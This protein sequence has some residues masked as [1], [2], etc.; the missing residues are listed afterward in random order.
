MQ[1]IYK[2]KVGAHIK[3]DAQVAGELCDRL[4]KDGRL[5]PKNL[6]D[7]CRPEGAP[8]HEVFEWDDGVAAEKYRE[9][10][11]SHIIRCVITV[12]ERKPEDEK[13]K[14]KPAFI[15]VSS[16]K[17]NDPK[18]STYVNTDAALS[19]ADYR[20]VIL[21]NALR[22]LIAF[23]NKYARL[24]ELANVFKEIDQ[25]KLDFGL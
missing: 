8:L 20:Q 19:N 16:H 7:E 17:S 1:M 9:G 2:W 6:L 3:A 14:Q 22:E 12:P 10:Q 13:P 24:N 11:A 5:T 21:K 25:L 23:K 18:K 4:D 15:L